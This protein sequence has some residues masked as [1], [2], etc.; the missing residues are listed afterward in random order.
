M[1]ACLVGFGIALANGHRPRHTWQLAFCLA[2]MPA[3]TAPRPALAQE[4]DAKFGVPL[5]SRGMLTR[6]VWRRSQ[7]QLAHQAMNGHL[8]KPSQMFRPKD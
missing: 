5:K 7:R 8:L 6:K 4:S 2:T 1:K 3:A